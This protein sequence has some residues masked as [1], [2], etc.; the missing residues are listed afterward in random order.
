MALLMLEELKEETREL[1][2]EVGCKV[3]R[4]CF[5]TKD[6][7]KFFICRKGKRIGTANVE[8][9]ST[10]KHIKELWQGYHDIVVTRTNLRDGVFWVANEIEEVEVFF[11][12]ANREIIEEMK[13]AIRA[14]LEE[15]Q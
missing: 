2:K 3:P 15:L 6:R 9:F 4:N 12:D 1:A 7:L 14:T 8:F 11:L 5:L 10:K 13:P